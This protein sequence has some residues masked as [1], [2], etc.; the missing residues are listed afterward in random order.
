MRA[1][2]TLETGDCTSPAAER[3]E[4]QQSFD[5]SGGDDPAAGLSQ[6]P[7]ADQWPECGNFFFMACDLAAVEARHKL[8]GLATNF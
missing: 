1:S 3:A 6:T 2:E 8:R 7:G 4:D 5:R